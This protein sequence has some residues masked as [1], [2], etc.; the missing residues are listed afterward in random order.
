MAAGD[1]RASDPG[2]LDR[3]QVALLI[4][5]YELTMAASYRARG[6]NHPAVFEHFVRRLPPNRAW[7]LAAGLAPTLE[8][9]RHLR[10]GEAELDYLREIGF[11]PAFVDHLAGFRFTGDI[12]AVPEGTIVFANEPII[13]VRAPLIE[14]QLLE[15]LILNQVNFQTMIASKAARVVLAAG[16][17]DAAGS[18]VDFSPR[19]DHGTDA[20][21]KVARS[22][23]VA[24]LEATSNVAVAMRFGLRAAG[25]MAHSYVL[26]FPSELEA[27]EAYLADDPDNAVLLV[28]TFD[29][30]KGVRNAIEA[31]RRTG[32]ALNGIRL[33]SG[34]LLELSN[35]ARR[36]LDAAGL[37][38]ARITASGDLDE[39]RIGALVEAGAP[40]D[41]WG[42]GTELGTSR[43]SPVV[44]GIY[45]LVATRDAAGAWRDVEKRSPG[46]ETRG[47]AKQ[48]FR[49][50]EGGRM[51]ADTVA[52]WGSC[53]EGEALLIPVMRAGE[54]VHGEGL[55]EIR[56]RSRAQINALPD[57]LRG[58]EAVGSYPVRVS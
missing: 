28:D 48:V 52:P 7:L 6:M 1:P 14:A 35:E 58:L 15:T 56:A 11:D 19:R 27:F 25:T 22:A 32:V 16:G 41:L 5:L 3:K 45:K 12:N 21:M 29:S 44:N 40:I 43:D 20:A 2:L 46:K 51:V 42:V 4:D 47:G 38:D 17:P 10:F 54:I 37:E 9:I 33:D 39:A 18:V 31:S 23:A 49:L 30:V 53:E 24:G 8:L 55:E 36:L 13:Q 26:S 57:A 34:N 50:V